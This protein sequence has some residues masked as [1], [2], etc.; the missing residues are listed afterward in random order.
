[1]NRIHSIPA[2]AEELALESNMEGWHAEGY[3]AG[4]G[5]FSSRTNPYDPF[6]AAGRAWE[7]GFMQA[8][9]V[10]REMRECGCA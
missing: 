5:R 7:A 8:V 10:Q 6:S 1:M 4:M 3:D 2:T 9:S